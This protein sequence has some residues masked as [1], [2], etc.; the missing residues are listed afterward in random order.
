MTSHSANL[1]EEDEKGD[2]GE[3]ERQRG[4]SQGEGGEDERRKKAA[5]PPVTYQRVRLAR[6]AP[7]HVC[8][9]KSP[10][11]LYDL[12][13]MFIH[14]DTKSTVIA[15]FSLL[16]RSPALVDVGKPLCEGKH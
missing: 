14:L 4:P 10:R 6:L 12:A 5:T 13:M 8:S 16:I 11:A 3:G 2:E 15:V 1:E 7:M 9:R